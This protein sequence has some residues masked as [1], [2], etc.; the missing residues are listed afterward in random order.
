MCYQRI[1][2]YSCSHSTR[3]KPHFCRYKFNI[4][5]QIE[6]RITYVRELCKD[7][8]AG[9]TQD[10]G[11][12]FC[13]HKVNGESRIKIRELGA[14]EREEG[15]SDGESAWKRKLRNRLISENENG[16]EEILRGLMLVDEIGE[17]ESEWK[18]K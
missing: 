5:H 10:L 15:V 9:K 4:N 13:G 14:D 7:C 8:I 3:W 11:A 17:V 6:P 12:A 16:S 18:R 2:K 1:D